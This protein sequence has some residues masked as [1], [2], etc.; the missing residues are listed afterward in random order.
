MISDADSDLLRFEEK[1][2]FL[3]KKLNR[4]TV[5]VEDLISDIENC[6]RSEDNP[7]GVLTGRLS[8]YVTC[9]A[10]DYEGLVNLY[11]TDKNHWKGRVHEIKDEKE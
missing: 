6:V 2:A 9:I 4:A 8:D 10:I 7:N 1:K 11:K 3:D 5:A